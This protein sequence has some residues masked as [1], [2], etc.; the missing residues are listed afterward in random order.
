M[1]TQ[2]STQAAPAASVNESRRSLDREDIFREAITI[3]E[4]VDWIVSA[5]A[6]LDKVR[7]LVERD[8]A[9]ADKFSQADIRHRSPCWYDNGMSS[10]V[11]ALLAHQYDLI[12]QLGGD[13]NAV[14]SPSFLC[15]QVQS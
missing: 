5:Q 14:D 4:V 7:T 3:N 15:G 11:A 1:A 2:Q 8:P 12:V 10:G 6:T 13:L 9:V